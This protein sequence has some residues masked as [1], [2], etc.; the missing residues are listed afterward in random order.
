MGS[1]QTGA[2]TGGSW[3]AAVSA[4]IS[5]GN[6]AV[7]APDDD[8]DGEWGAG[9]PPH[10]DD[11]AWRHPS[12]MRHLFGMA[13]PAGPSLVSLPSRRSWGLAVVSAFL[14]AAVV[15]GLWVTIGAIDIRTVHITERVPLSPLDSTPPRLV[16][17]EDW[18]TEVAREVWPSLARVDLDTGGSAS[19]LVVRDDGLLVTAAAPIAGER[20]VRVVL[21]DG[22]RLSATVVGTDPVT[23]LAVLRI[24]QDGLDPAVLQ[25]VDGPTAGDVGVVVGA[26]DDDAV[27]GRVEVSRPTAVIR[28]DRGFHPDLLALDGGPTVAGAPVVDRSG[29]VV[30]V[31]TSLAGGSLSYAVPI[32]SAR[33]VALDLAG[34]GVVRHDGWL[35]ID[36]ADP[37]AEA[38]V[39]PL[40]EGTVRV[41]RV[42]AGGPAAQAG[43]RAGDVISTIDGDPVRN[44]DRFVVLV[45][46]LAADTSVEVGYF[47]DGELRTATVRLGGRPAV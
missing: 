25:R 1:A 13:T 2:R 7:V 24:D 21:T 23:D 5:L 20:E 45:R 28:D 35:G 37:G 17:A 18:A 11:R 40:L 4:P 31:M 41:T 12:E 34:G 38:Q 14:G 9:P 26:A 42:L 3:E 19:A 15:A 32:E 44:H 36:A 30:A 47:R 43:L 8:A 46:S 33:R 39:F 6:L 16:A 22:R 27:V 29:A 10:P